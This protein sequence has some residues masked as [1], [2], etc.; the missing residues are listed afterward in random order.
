MNHFI[1]AGRFR[2]S[3]TEFLSNIYVSRKV[4]R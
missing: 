4:W 1:L 3:I 2:T